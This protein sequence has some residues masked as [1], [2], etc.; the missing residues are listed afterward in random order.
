MTAL[1]P[2][3]PV[4]TALSPSHGDV[5]NDAS[6]IR[7]RLDMTGAEGCAVRALNVIV[8]RG[9]YL[10]DAQL[11]AGMPGDKRVL[12][13]R[14]LPRDEARLTP[15]LIRQLERLYDVETVTV[16]DDADAVSSPEAA[17]HD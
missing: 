7:L 10:Y 17:S 2:L 1:Y 13:V 4:E 6:P 16:L 3:R 11:D 12:T 9:W 8:R 14:V 5:L 15:T